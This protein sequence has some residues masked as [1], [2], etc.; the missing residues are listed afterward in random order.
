MIIFMSIRCSLFSLS[1][2]C[3]ADDTQHCLTDYDS[4][5]CWPKTLRGTVAHLPCLA[6]LKGV[7]YDITSELKSRNEREKK[8]NQPKQ[9]TSF[10]EIISLRCNKLFNLAFSS[11]FLFFL[12]CYAF[13]CSPNGSVSTFHY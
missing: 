2:I 3:Q 5:L 13:V 9:L 4:I 11:L 6:E 8:N 7:H 1:H 10:C 12:S